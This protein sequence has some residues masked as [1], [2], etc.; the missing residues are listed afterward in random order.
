[1][2]FI[3]MSPPPVIFKFF[4]LGQKF[5]CFSVFPIWCLSFP[6]LVKWRERTGN[7]K[8][9]LVLTRKACKKGCQTAQPAELL[10]F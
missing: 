4:Q 9:R 2:E 7:V 5:H 6:Q 10:T 8:A 3:W 1:M